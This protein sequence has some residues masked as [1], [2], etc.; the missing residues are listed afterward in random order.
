M[1][2]SKIKLRFTKMEGL[3]NDFMVINAV[4]Q[5]IPPAKLEKLYS[6]N[7][8]KK[9][10]DRHFGIGFDQM[11]VVEPPVHPQSDFHYRIFNA[12]GSEVGNC[13]NGARCFARFV[14][15][16]RLTQKNEIVVDIL[17]G[18]KSLMLKLNFNKSVTVD[19]GSPIYEAADIPLAPS[20]AKTHSETSGSP[21]HNITL[22]VAGEEYEF[23]CLS[24]GN[25]HAVTVVKD[26]RNVP[27]RE[28]GRAL[29]EHPCFPES[30]N[31]GFMQIL[32]TDEIMLRVYERGVG[33]TLA[34]GTG[35]CAAV[36]AG[37]SID[38]LD[39]N[40]AVQLRGGQLTIEHPL[41][42]G[43]LPDSRVYMT[44]PAQTVF[45]GQILI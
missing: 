38:I 15:Q 37:Q 40:V 41:S 23:I 5:Q 19:M 10:G 29:Q 42:E 26:I 25:P 8:I 4:T 28:I 31:V 22:D 45:V 34:C 20:E 36:V 6:P 17:D 3:G 9:I 35:A 33:E 14:Q 18:K 32:S 16:E 44:G 30:V 11:L 7:F 21:A 13:G 1:E 39:D 24:M 43:Y 2:Y 27:I 12:D